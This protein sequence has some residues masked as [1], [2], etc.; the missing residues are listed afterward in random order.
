MRARSAWPGLCA[1]AAAVLLAGQPA[2][3]RAATPE[4]EVKAAYLFKIASFVRWPDGAAG[5]TFRICVTGRAD[6]AG[7]LGQLTAD[8]L[9]DG[10]RISVTQ[11]GGRD[12]AQARDCQILFVGRSGAQARTLI[13]ATGRAPVLLVTDRNSGTRGGAVEFVVQDGRVRFLINRGEAESRQLV[14]SSKLLDVAAGVTR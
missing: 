14:L 9:I 12:A 7:T 8:Q 11:L 6:I 3:L 13:A 2:G 1:A 5:G 4:V 10:K